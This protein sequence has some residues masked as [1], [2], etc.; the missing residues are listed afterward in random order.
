LKTLLAAPVPPGL[1]PKATSILADIKA[2]EKRHSF[3]TFAKVLPLTPAQVSPFSSDLDSSADSTSWKGSRGFVDEFVLISRRRSADNGWAW[4]DEE[5]EGEGEDVDSSDDDFLPTTSWPAPK[6]VSEQELF[7]DEEVFLRDNV[8][9]TT[10]LP[11]GP[12]KD[13]YNDDEKMI[14]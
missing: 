11:V 1:S 13:L 2:M 5:G 7:G 12:T 4:S 10:T 3:T 14:V 6:G 8:V 9:I